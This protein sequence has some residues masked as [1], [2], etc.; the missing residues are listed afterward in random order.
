MSL[1]LTEPSPSVGL[2]KPNQP[3]PQVP[4]GSNNGNSRPIGFNI[5]ITDADLSSSPPIAQIHLPYPTT[6]NFPPVSLS[7]SIYPDITKAHSTN[8]SSA[9]PMENSSKPPTHAKPAV[10]RRPGNGIAAQISKFQ[11]MGDETPSLEHS[12]SSGSESDRQSKSSS[13]IT[14]L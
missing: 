5:S 6:D 1:K 12:H 10:P 3:P 8:L 14:S 11:K 2:E 13:E 9:P 4:L 7:T